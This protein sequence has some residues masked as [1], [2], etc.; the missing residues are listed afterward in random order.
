MACVGK[1]SKYTVDGL[2]TH[3]VAAHTAG[4]E[5]EATTTSMPRLSN[6]QRIKQA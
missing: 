4:S 6:M 5:L 2:S 3:Q 1:E